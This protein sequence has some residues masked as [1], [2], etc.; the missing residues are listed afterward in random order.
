MSGKIG[1]RDKGSIRLYNAE[2]VEVTGNYFEGA[3][4]GVYL[5]RNSTAPDI[6]TYSSDTKIYIYN[7]EFVDFYSHAIKLPRCPYGKAVIDNNTF[8]RIYSDYA[9]GA[10]NIYGSA[11]TAGEEL[12]Y[13]YEVTNNTFT[14]VQKVFNFQM[15]V[16]GDDVAPLDVTGKV[17]IEKTLSILIPRMRLTALLR[18]F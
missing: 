15:Y 13:D 8:S 5:T 1:Y 12:P 18:S 11:T 4:F 17:K 7:N 2:N 3:A 10:V 6:D 16:Y 9:E 14:D